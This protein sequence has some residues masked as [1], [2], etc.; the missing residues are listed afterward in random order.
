MFTVVLLCLCVIVFTVVVVVA[1]VVIVFCFYFVY[2]SILYGISMFLFSLH[3]KVN[4]KG[5]TN[6]IEATEN[7]SL[8]IIPFFLIR[9][10]ERMRTK[11]H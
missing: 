9:K 8:S 10:S 6:E 11:M 4:T 5:C 7:K 1:I 3:M 2:F